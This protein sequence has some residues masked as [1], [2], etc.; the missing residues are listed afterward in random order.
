MPSDQRR[1]PSLAR[2]NGQKPRVLIV[3]DNRDFAENI[4]EVVEDLDFHAE[5]ALTGRQAMDLFVEHP[6]DVAVIDLQ[7]PDFPG[8]QV[9]AHIK[10]VC[11]DCV[12]IVFTGNATLHNAVDALNHGAFA[13][14]TKGGEVDEF[15]AVL[16]NAI[17]AHLTACELRQIRGI[18]QA[19]LENFPGRMVIL[20]AENRVL[21][22]NQYPLP[23][24]GLQLD[25]STPDGRVGRGI[26]EAFPPSQPWCA[27][28]IEH[29]DRQ[30]GSTEASLLP[31]LAAPGLDGNVRF[32][33]A[34][35][36]PLF[37][38]LARCLIVV[39]DVT[40]A[41]QMER[42]VE[43][44]SR[45]AAVGEL[46]ATIAHEVR[47][48][49]SGISGA[50]QIL[51]KKLPAGSTDREI[52]DQVI[53]QIDRLN[54]TI[55]D[56]LVLSRPMTP[57]FVESTMTDILESVLSFLREDPNFKNVAIETDLDGVAARCRLDPFL[58]RQAIVNL[59][60]NAAQAM[61]GVG[62]I[63]VGITCAQG[64]I[65][66]KIQDSGPGLPPDPSR[67]FE[68]FYT[69]KPAGTGLGLPITA[70]ILDVHGGSIALRNHERGGAEITLTIPEHAL[71][72][73]IPRVP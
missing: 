46:A 57:K 26:E 39:E 67:L 3:D 4:A 8:T 30:R 65:Q 5:I 58:F 63:R 61:G 27:T 12:C 34:R 69:T 52:C 31:R 70:K 43:K 11:A 71:P 28:L 10:D 2:I 16:A 24:A 25:S 42:E 22:S 9:I 1:K 53:S 47:N 36:V 21:L 45:L 54:T 23:L 15:R 72:P 32:Y 48:P 73:R 60:I 17:E 64:K 59:M 56:L 38:A 55:E 49:L 66:V 41:V 6:F 29:Y 51:R 44:T 40:Q 62:T 33:D 50:I 14:L 19:I 7:L 20:D 35:F 18:N 37:H 13:Y 68:P